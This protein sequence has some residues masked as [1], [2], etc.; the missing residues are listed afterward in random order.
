MKKAH[1]FAVVSSI[2]IM[3]M[4]GCNGLAEIETFDGVDW[5]SNFNSQGVAVKTVLTN[6]DKSTHLVTIKGQEK[7]HYHD[8]HDLF[9]YVTQGNVKIHFKNRTE[10]L[11][12]GDT[13]MIPKGTYHWA[14]NTN[15]DASNMVVVFTPPFDKKDRRFV[16]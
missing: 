9:A 13:V 10:F 15:A 6:T 4:S 1:F 7:P 8:Q 5:P 12:V 2:F 11:E 14:E 16:D 3:G